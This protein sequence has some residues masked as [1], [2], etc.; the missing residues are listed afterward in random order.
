MDYHFGSLD[1]V[2][3][4]YELNRPSG[5]GCPTENFVEK[6]A[7]IHDHLNQ[8]IYKAVPKDGAV[9]IEDIVRE[10]KW[11]DPKTPELNGWMLM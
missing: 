11:E 4:D 2:A 7:F 10:S 3:S 5:L 6:A 8:E 1:R 9:D